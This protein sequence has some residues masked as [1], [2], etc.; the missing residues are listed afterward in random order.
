M[1]P[2]D[3]EE[4][5][6]DDDELEAQVLLI[7]ALSIMHHFISLWLSVRVFSAS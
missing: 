5:D 6:D 4:D 7:I 1:L 3:D 2:D